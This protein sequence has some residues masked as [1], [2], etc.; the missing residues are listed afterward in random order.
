MKSNLD[1]IILIHYELR[2]SWISGIWISLLETRDMSTIWFGLFEMNF[3][4]IGTTIWIVL[5]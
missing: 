3:K 2:V 4:T 1:H 5:E